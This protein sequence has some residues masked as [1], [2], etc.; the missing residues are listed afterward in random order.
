M[1]KRLLNDFVFLRVIGS[2]LTRPMNHIWVTA[3][4][5]GTLTAR[6]NNMLKIKSCALKLFMINQHK[7][8]EISQINHKY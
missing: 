7:I 4:K 8:I 5:C 6:F 2:L 1:V 3:M